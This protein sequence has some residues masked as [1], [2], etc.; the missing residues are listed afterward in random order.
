M[1]IAIAILYL[2]PIALS[3]A[4]S[5]GSPARSSKRR[6]PRFRRSARGGVGRRKGC[7]RA[8]Q[9]S[10]PLS[11]FSC[12]DR[13]SALFLSVCPPVYLSVSSHPSPP[14]FHPSAHLCIPASMHQ[15][16]HPFIRA[17]V[18][19]CIHAE[20]TCCRDCTMSLLVR[21]WENDVYVTYV[22]I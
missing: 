16:R 6:G 2:Y 12:D 9:G 14:S 11:C 17:S 4:P 3:R 21:S 18:N 13:N 20:L 19:P 15:C 1:T 22:Y 10:R 7:R 8:S 5:R